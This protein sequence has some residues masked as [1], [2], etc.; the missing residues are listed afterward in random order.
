MANGHQDVDLPP[1]SLHRAGGFLADFGAFL[2]GLGF[3]TW[4]V[5]KEPGGHLTAFWLYVVLDAHCSK[6]SKVQFGCTRFASVNL[7]IHAYARGK[8]PHLAAAVDLLQHFVQQVWRPKDEP[9]QE[10]TP[11]DRLNQNWQRVDMRPFL[12]PATHRLWYSCE[13]DSLSFMPDASGQCSI[14]N[15]WRAYQDEA[16]HGWWCRETS[17][18]IFFPA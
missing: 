13:D 6:R 12:C 15:H 4:T 18:H 14:C 3:H 7:N 10:P 2:R 16:G 17:G 5:Q 8:A 11:E 1:S 9:N